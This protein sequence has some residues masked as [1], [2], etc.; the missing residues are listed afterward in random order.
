MLAAWLPGN[1]TYDNP[2]AARPGGC[3]VQY[4]PYPP[5]R[6]MRGVGKNRAMNTASVSTLLEQESGTKWVRLRGERHGVQV[7]LRPGYQALRRHLARPVLP[8]GAA[9]SASRTS[10]AP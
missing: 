7:R 5:R 3:L 10:A 1:S 2:R 9:A 4:F 6:P 8:F